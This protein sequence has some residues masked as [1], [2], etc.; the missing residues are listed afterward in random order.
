MQTKL[1]LKLNKDSISRAKNYAYKN[2]RSL[3][4]IVEDYFDNLTV[5]KD[6]NQKNTSKLVRELKGVISLP[7]NYNRKKDYTEFLLKKY[8]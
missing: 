5:K 8:K 2:S 4:K 1:T 3:S 7:K 6:I